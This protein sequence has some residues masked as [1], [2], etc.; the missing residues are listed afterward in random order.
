MCAFIIF[1]F[2]YLH[3]NVFRNVRIVRVH[4]QVFAIEH[5][6]RMPIASISLWNHTRPFLFKICE[7]F[8]FFCS[9]YVVVDDC[10]RQSLLKCINSPRV[11]H[12]LVF[13]INFSS[14]CILCSSTLC[15]YQFVI[16]QLANFARFGSY[17][18]TI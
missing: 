14:P 1:D 13:G 2:F 12:Q 5:N 17:N 4:A 10:I 11:R 3:V 7:C 8:L 9:A 6:V 18:F 15:W 16:D